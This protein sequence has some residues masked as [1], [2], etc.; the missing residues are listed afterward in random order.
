MLNLETMPRDDETKFHDWVSLNVLNAIAST[1]Q[2]PFEFET[3]ETNFDCKLMVLFIALF[4]KKD[5]YF[6]VEVIDHMICLKKA[7]LYLYKQ[8][9]IDNDTFKVQDHEKFKEIICIVENGKLYR[10]LK[11]YYDRQETKSDTIIDKT[12][13]DN[14]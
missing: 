12:F 13:I 2:V 4:C 6:G 3:K 9:V 1:D 14:L 11:S 8:L 7:I 10:L 5:D